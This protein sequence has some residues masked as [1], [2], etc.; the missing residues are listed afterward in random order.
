MIISFDIDNTL[1]PYSNEF[2]TEQVSWFWKVMGAEPI[3]DGSIDLFKKLEKDGHQLWIYTTSFRSPF[4]LKKTFFAH[5]LQPK[6][7]INQDVN[8]RELKKHQC[9]ASKHPGLFGIDLHIDDSEG[10]RIE[11]EQYHFNTLIVR[12]DDTGWV[13]KV[14]NAVGQLS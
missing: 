5:G 7:I 2:K 12:P 10:V 4:S 6:R 1:I 8:Q 9:M 11:G 13:E 3:R 14:I